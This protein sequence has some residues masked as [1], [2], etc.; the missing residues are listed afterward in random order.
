MFALRYTGKRAALNEHFA[1]A[2]V[3]KNVERVYDV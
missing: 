2:Y 1:D 3:R